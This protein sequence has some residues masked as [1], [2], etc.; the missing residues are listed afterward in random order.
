[1]KLRALLG[2]VALIGG[3]MF[4]TGQVVSQE[5]GEKGHEHKHGEGDHGGAMM[6]AWAKAATPGEFHAHLKPLAGQWNNTTK[7]R[8]DAS[9]P[10]MES[11]GKSEYKWIMD[12]RFLLQEVASEMMGDRFEGLGI[13]GY[14][15]VQKKYT[16]VWI[17]TMGTMIFTS[18]GSCDASGKVITLHGDYVDVMSGQKKKVRSVCRMIN[19]NKHVFEMYD[20]TADGKEYMSL[21][22]TYT[23]K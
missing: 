16:S 10:W 17:D 11:T 7:W 3:L 5:H 12:G 22:V 20:R 15:N 23:R 13:L 6:E 8:F 21:E 14:D 4:F 9:A 18:L 19:D 2:G 1:M